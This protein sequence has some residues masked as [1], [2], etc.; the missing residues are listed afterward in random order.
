[1]ASSVTCGFA[2]QFFFALLDRGIGGHIRRAA[3]RILNRPPGQ[4]AGFDHIVGGGGVV[5]LGVP[6]DVDDVRLERHLQ[7]DAG[8]QVRAG[9]V[10]IQRVAEQAGARLPPDAEIRARAKRCRSI[11]STAS[12]LAR[13]IAS[14]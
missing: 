10:R 3:Q 11:S 12:I 13:S 7:V 8:C 2:D 5:R 4:L 14:E 6:D 9:R 1:M